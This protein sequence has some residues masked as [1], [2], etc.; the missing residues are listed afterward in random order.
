[1]FHAT[2]EPI[3]STP[4]I[5]TTVPIRPNSL[6][7]STRPLRGFD[8]LGHGIPRPVPSGQRFG[9]AV[10]DARV[11]R[12]IHA[13]DEVVAVE[14]AA[15]HRA[16]AVSDAVVRAREQLV[17]RVLRVAVVFLELVGAAHDVLGDAL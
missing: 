9:D 6:R 10:I 7:A 16:A 14:H 12:V 8:R 5:N 13:T 3:A 11:A 15:L 17:E 1:M 4:T 2:S